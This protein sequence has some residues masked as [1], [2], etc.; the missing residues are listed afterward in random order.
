MKVSS[1]KC[2]LEH[3]IS[4]MVICGSYLFEFSVSKD[5]KSNEIYALHKG[6]WQ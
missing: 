5:K 1:L 2:K 4:T 6:R 3:K